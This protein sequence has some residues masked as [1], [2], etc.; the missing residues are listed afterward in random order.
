M[1]LQNTFLSLLFTLV[2]IASIDAAAQSKAY[3]RKKPAPAPVSGTAAGTSA[4]APSADASAP[5]KSG[6]E[7]LDITELEQKYWAP[8]DTDFSVVQN[9]TYTKAGRFAVTASMGPTVNDPFNEGLISG[10]QA[11]YYIDERYGFELMYLSSDLSDSDATDNFLKFSGGDTRPDFNRD[12]SY[13]GAGFNWVP[14]YAKMSFLGKKII[15][16]DMQITPHIGIS[17]YEQ[18]SIVK[19]PEQ[20][21]F[22]YGLDVT[23]YFFFSK[24]FAIRATLHNRYFKSDVLAYDDGPGVSAGQVKRSGESAN[25]TNFLMGVT[26]F[27]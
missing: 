20:T 7:K 21:A 19:T 14:F 26:Y 16:F 22:S 9:R 13:V 27:F 8:K 4:P 6:S 15:Y 11:N 17:T 24:H 3:Q 25:T 23:Q 5:A 18:Q 2:W 1:R 12:V 10:I